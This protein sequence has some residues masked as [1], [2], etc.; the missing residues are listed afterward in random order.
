ML[1]T[2]LVDDDRVSMELLKT[3]CSEI[4]GIEIIGTF[5]NPLEALGFSQKN[6]VDFAL[7]DIEMEPMDGIELG[8][9]LK[10]IYPEMVI[11]YVTGHSEYAIEAMKMK[12]DFYVLK[13]Y[14]K[15]DIEDAL[16]RAKLL[17]KRQNKRVFIRTFGRFDVFVDENPIFFRSTKAKEL[18]AIMV[19]NRGGIV[20]SE[21]AITLLWEDRPF[22]ASSQALLR[23]VVQRLNENLKNAGIGYILVSDF[24]GRYLDLSKFDCDYYQYLDGNISKSKFKGEY[25]IEYSWAEDTVAKLT[26]NKK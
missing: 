14:D 1:K 15:L 5:K 25:M 16:N 13:P 24:K 19:D 11:I 3:E 22:D 6:K 9:R 10:L 23:K 26:F 20:T 18:L 17:S 8:K 21:Q 7:L 4:N 2:I 12:A